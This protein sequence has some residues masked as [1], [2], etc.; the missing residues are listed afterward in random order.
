MVCVPST[1]IIHGMCP[2]NLHHSWYVSHDLHHSWY[3][4]HQPTSFMVCVPS[5]YIIHGM[6]PINLHHSW[7]V[8]HQP[9]S[10][11]VFVPSTYIIHG[12]CPINLHHSWYVSHP[13]EL[14]RRFELLLK[15]IHKS[16][17][18]YRSIV[19]FFVNLNQKSTIIILYGFSCVCT[20]ILGQAC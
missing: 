19:L 4:S 1:Y 16:N 13:T 12:I 15:F 9:T 3:V 8:S 17:M 7:Y 5:T 10:F 18:V 14:K 2:I 20:G 6:C 11:M